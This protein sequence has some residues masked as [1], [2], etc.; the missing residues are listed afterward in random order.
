MITAEEL[1]KYNWFDVAVNDFSIKNEISLVLIFA[2]K[3]E[4]NDFV[5]DV[6]NKEPFDV[7]IQ[8]VD[9]CFDFTIVTNLGSDNLLLTLQSEILATNYGFHHWIKSGKT[10]SI[11]SGIWAYGIDRMFDC[12]GQYWLPVE[13]LVLNYEQI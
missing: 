13:R 6:L 12:G 2:T 5:I 4:G 8:V 1:Q 11:T 3:E 9:K 7:I 10:F